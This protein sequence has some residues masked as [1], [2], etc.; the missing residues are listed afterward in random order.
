MISWSHPGIDQEEQGKRKTLVSQDE[1]IKIIETLGVRG[2]FILA[3][4]HYIQ[5]DV[6]PEN[7]IALRDAVCG[8]RY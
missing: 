8:H 6:P 1:A 3:P 2:G 5:P 4:T 7:L